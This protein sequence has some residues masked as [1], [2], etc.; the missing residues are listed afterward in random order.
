MMVVRFNAFNCLK[1]Y[2]GE[3][4]NDY[5]ITSVKQ[6]NSFRWVLEIELLEYIKKHKEEIETDMRLS[7]RRSAANKNKKTRKKRTRIAS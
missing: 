6:L 5:V 1:F 2:Y 4:K 3:G 7:L